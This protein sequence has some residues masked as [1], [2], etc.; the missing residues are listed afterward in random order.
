M[1]GRNGIHL[2]I[3]AGPLTAEVEFV[4]ANSTTKWNPDSRIFIKVGVDLCSD[5]R[6]CGSGRTA[7]ALEGFA[8]FNATVSFMPAADPNA[9]T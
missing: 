4:M 6:K 8:F 3:P 1:G 2:P 9:A 5:A 7:T